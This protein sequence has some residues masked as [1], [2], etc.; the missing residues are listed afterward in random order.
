MREP[1]GLGRGFGPLFALP[2]GSREVAEVV[3]DLKRN[4]D[5]AILFFLRDDLNEEPNLVGFPKG[6]DAVETTEEPSG[7]DVC[8]TM[9][10]MSIYLL[11]VVLEVLRFS[12]FIVLSS[13][14]LSCQ[15]QFLGGYHNLKKRTTMLQTPLLPRGDKWCY[16]PGCLT[17]SLQNDVCAE[18]EF[19]FNLRTE[20]KSSSVLLLMGSH[21]SASVTEWHHNSHG[22]PVVFQYV[23]TSDE[24]G[25]EASST[26]TLIGVKWSGGATP[27]HYF[28]F[29]SKLYLHVYRSRMISNKRRTA[30]A[31]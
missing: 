27:A 4:H 6:D 28:N 16:S 8:R 23:Y 18:L 17:F 1:N 22:K 26:H 29:Q 3:P 20:S 24:W 13:S 14:I 25:L 7:P 2:Y 11:W 21:V 10:V 15:D 31:V 9:F 5:I 30:A 19:H 12:Q